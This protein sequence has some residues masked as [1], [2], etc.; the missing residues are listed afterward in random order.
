MIYSLRRKFI[1]ICTLSI[2]TVLL[3]MLMAIFASNHIQ[4]NRMLDAICDVISSNGGAFPEGNAL[5]FHE[6]KDGKIRPDFINEETPFITRFFSVSFG[7]DGTVSKINTDYTASLSQD[8]AES[9]ARAV[10]SKKKTSGWRDDYRYRIYENE[11]TTTVV[12]VNGSMFR[13]TS[14]SYLFSTFGVFAI[15]SLGVLIMIIV[16]SKK[17]VKPAAESYEKQKQFITDANHELKTPLTLI[18]A[19]IDIAE[20]ELGQNE[21]LDDIRYEG[22]HM[23]KLVNRLVMLSRMDEG[24]RN[25]PF[26]KFNLSD[27]VMDTVSEFTDVA[28]L[29]EKSLSCELSD[30]II[31]CGCEAEIRQLVAI[32]LDNAVKYCDAGGDI[33]VQLKQKKRPLLL[34]SN[35]YRDVGKIQLD[36]LFERFYRVDHAR[37]SGSDFGIGLSIAHSIVSHHHGEISALQE[38]EDRICFKIKL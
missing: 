18:L 25:T 13:F 11:G 20:S 6:P 34:V 27:A 2:L 14:N 31:L 19:N 32:L 23:S 24:N 7:A 4:Q 22:Q 9:N 35:S 12:F 37:T 38:S 17:A 29:N 5:K 3:I 21:W 1:G 16:I 10:L 36:R 33:R 15:G 28:A 26:E 30:D 8:E